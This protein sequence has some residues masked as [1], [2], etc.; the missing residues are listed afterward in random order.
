M[1]ESIEG[2][3]DLNILRYTSD[4]SITWHSE[5]VQNVIMGDQNTYIP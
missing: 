2:L 4:G 5:V 1:R 3:I